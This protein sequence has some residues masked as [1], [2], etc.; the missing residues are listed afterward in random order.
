MGSARSIM[1]DLRV[2]RERA[3]DDVEA[4][5]SW[6]ARREDC[7]GKIGVIGFCLRGGVRVD[8]RAGARLSGLERQLWLGPEGRLLRRRALR[9]LRAVPRAVS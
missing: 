6:L 1:R 9:F 3:F 4:V 7:T 5:R 8:A 2:R